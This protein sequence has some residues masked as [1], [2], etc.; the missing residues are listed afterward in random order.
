GAKTVLATCSPKSA[1]KAKEYGAD[2][3]VDY[4]KGAEHEYKEITEFV[5]KNGKFD[6]IFDSCRDPVFMGRLK[7]V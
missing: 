1:A 5:K 4:T 2:V 6:L 3:I 7:D